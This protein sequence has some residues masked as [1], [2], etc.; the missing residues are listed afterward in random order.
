MKFATT[1]IGAYPIAFLM[2]LAVACKK[3]NDVHSR[4]MLTYKV[5]CDTCRF[6]WINP[7]GNKQYQSIGQDWQHTMFADEGQPVHIKAWAVT[8]SANITVGIY[9]E[10]DQVA[11]GYAAGPVDTALAT[12]VVRP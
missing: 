2:A 6:Y 11:T 12:W 7:T 5:N 1:R 4:P 3:D 8:P 9:H 10:G